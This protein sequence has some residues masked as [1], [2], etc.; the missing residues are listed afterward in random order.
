MVTQQED[1]QTPVNGEGEELWAKADMVSQPLRRPERRHVDALLDIS[2]ENSMREREPYEYV[3]YSRREDAVCGW[4]RAA[5]LSG[6]LMIQKNH[7]KPKQKKADNLTPLSVNPL[8]AGA[9]SSAS[10]SEQP[11]E[12]H[13]GLRNFKKSASP[14]QQTGS[15]GQTDFA[16][17]NATQK[18]RTHLFHDEKIDGEGTL[19][20]TSLQPHHLSSKYSVLENRLTKP[21]KPSYKLNNT[22]VPIKNFTFL[23]PIKHQSSQL[24]PKVRCHGG[25]GTKGTR[26]DTRNSDLDT[27]S[28]A[29]TSVYQTCQ[30][31]PF[32]FPAFCA[33]VPKKSQVLASPKPDAAQPL[34]DKSLLH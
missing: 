34:M 27:N 14:N 28:A 9:N 1:V 8:P 25:S 31:K 3:S 15:W 33:P 4:A 26:M 6:I 23:P 10:F 12:S 30:D 20:H 24:N 11:C 16:V 19:R 17:L 22:M 2:E 7:R 29:L 21:Q 13:A 5:P 32:L 18:N